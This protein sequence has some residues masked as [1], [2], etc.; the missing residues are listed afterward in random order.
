MKR[1]IFCKSLMAAA[2]VF[3]AFSNSG[4]SAFAQKAKTSIEY[5]EN[6]ESVRITVGKG[7]KYDF[8]SVQA[9]IDSINYTPTEKTRAVIAIYPGE[10]EEVVNINKPYVTLT[11]ANGKNPEDV[12]I[13]YDRAASHENPEK[14]FGTQQSA[15][16]TADKDAIGFTAEN[17]TIQNSYNLNQPNLG[18]DG[19]RAQTQAVALVTL[20]D[21]VILRNCHFLGRQDT[22]FLKGASKG[23]DVYGDSVQARVYAEDCLIEGTVDYIFGDATAY[24]Y[25]CDL[26]M[27]YYTN[28]GH[29]T[30]A[31]T[32]LFN[33]GYVFDRCR[34]T[35]DKK[36]DEFSGDSK[37]NVD[38]GRPWQGDSAYPNYGSHTVFLNCSMPEDILAEKG[39]SAWNDSTVTNKIRYY[40]YG[41][42]NE[43]G[44]KLDLSNRIEW[45]KIL[46]DRQ[47]Q[48]YNPFNILRGDDNWNP[49]NDNFKNAKVA[50]VTLDKYNIEIPEGEEAQIKAFVLPVIASNKNVKFSSD[51]ESIAKVDEKSGII[52]ALREGE[53]KI[54]AA[55]DENQ[56]TVSCNVKVLPKRTAPPTINKISVSANG[57]LQPNTVLTGSY[58]YKNKA[59]NDIDCAK[60]KWFSVDD[61]GNET[62][63]QEGREEFAR[64]YTLRGADI[65]NKI[66]FVVVPETD[67]SYGD[68]G[69]IQE[70]T[71]KEITADANYKGKTYLRDGFDD[72]EN[73]SSEKGSQT[74]DTVWIKSNSQPPNGETK[75]FISVETD[76]NNTVG[77]GTTDLS[78][79]EYQP[80]PNETPWQDLSL[81]TRMIFNPSSGGFSANCYYN[82][83]TNYNSDKGSYYKLKI[84]RGGN[85]NSLMLYLYKNDGSGDV[86]LA[87]DEESLKDKVYQNKGSENPWFRIK[88]V[89]KGNKIKVEFTLEGDSEPAAVLEAED[90][91]PIESGFIAFE[92]YGKV[93]VLLNDFVICEKAE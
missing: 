9:A 40:E 44:E 91:E 20:C 72:F 70:K 4:I 36:Y 80:K 28:G 84:E 93:G 15:T 2:A 18:D 61:K 71:S 51:N 77:G 38:L 83:L 14:K 75:S 37:K 89:N 46:T 41:S 8:S 82:I 52:T 10:Y 11:N 63:V 3:F 62:L 56:F 60:V 76:E 1:K 34:L 42:T 7:D 12:V 33:I 26:N 66:K 43:K 64:S 39:Y 21:K 48:A 59:D 29:Y 69:E 79:I 50:D 30:A 78:M 86:L 73:I 19:G 92:N 55:T 58:S 47:A 49:A 53:V 6:Q 24:F 81:E 32:T 67:T 74:E 54:T 35:A 85:T 57:K 65:G 45:E 16:V 25:N 13:T 87:S 88:Q 31:N 5:T 27:A 22:L 17:I 23:A 90:N 68:T